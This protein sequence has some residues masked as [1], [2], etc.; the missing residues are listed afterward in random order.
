MNRNLK[1]I[2]LLGS[3]NCK[4]FNLG[5]NMSTPSTLVNA[6]TAVSKVIIR[7]KKKSKQHF[8][9]IKPTLFFNPT[10]IT[11]NFAT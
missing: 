2:H 6:T 8:R 10:I 4:I 11:I 3:Q 5:S 9:I 1:L 7:C